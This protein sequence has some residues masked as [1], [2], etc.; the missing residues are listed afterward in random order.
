MKRFA[1]WL[2]THISTSL[3]CVPLST[4]DGVFIKVLPS[5]ELHLMTLSRRKI[6]Q[7]LALLPNWKRRIAKPSATSTKIR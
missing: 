7:I 6:G 5:Y 3:S 2:K 4:P 1:V